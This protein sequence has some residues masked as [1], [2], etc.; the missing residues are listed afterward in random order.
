MAISIIDGPAQG[1]RLYLRRAPLFLRVTNDRPEAGMFEMYGKWG[2][3]A[4][5]ADVPGQ[6]QL[7][8]AYRRISNDG[9][10]YPT[11]TYCLVADQPADEV[12]RDNDQWQAWCRAQLPPAE[13]KKEE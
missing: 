5:V 2:A 11:A 7:L 10:T 9:G 4:L 13:P 12:M 8:F 6:H 1:Q 3:L